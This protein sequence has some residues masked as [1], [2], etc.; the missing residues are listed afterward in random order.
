MRFEAK[1]RRPRFG[2]ASGLHGH[3]VEPQHSLGGRPTEGLNGSTVKPAPARRALPVMTLQSAKRP[4]ARVP[5]SR[6]NRLRQTGR[7][8]RGVG[9]LVDRQARGVSEP[10]R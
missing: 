1:S 9:V 8:E 3:T 2:R 10:D 7:T 5:A 6:F 4:P